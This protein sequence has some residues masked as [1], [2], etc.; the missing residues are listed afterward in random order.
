MKD[1]IVTALAALGAVGDKVAA[2]FDRLEDW[3]H[4]HPVAY[5]MCIGIPLGMVLT[6]PAVF[7]LSVIL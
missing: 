3:L 2:L 4:W 1:N 6:I 7:L 5:G